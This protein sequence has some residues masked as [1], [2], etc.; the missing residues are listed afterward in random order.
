MAKR[1]FKRSNP[2]SGAFTIL[3][4]LV[5]VGI[6]AVV[7]SIGY[8]FFR[9]YQGNGHLRSAARGI[10]ADFAEQK[11]RAM[12]GV[13]TGLSGVRVHRLT[14]NLGA[15]QYTLQ[16]C[17]TPDNLCPGWDD[18]QVRS[19]SQ[20]GNDIVFDPGGTNTTNVEFQT[21]GTVTPSPATIVLTNGRGSRATIESNIS[22]RTYV[23]FNMQ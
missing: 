8:P 3:E 23:A 5:V 17:K 18:I 12:T 9:Q 22:G 15:N 4:L 2:H 19:L 1:A 21:R 11:Q 14:L 7:M 16:R 10:V 6:L 13:L 20:Y